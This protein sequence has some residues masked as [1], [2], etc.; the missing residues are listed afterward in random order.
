MI[1]A[2]AY[3]LGAAF[4]VAFAGIWLGM[5]MAPYLGAMAEVRA[6]RWHQAGAV[7]KL[8]GPGL[9][10]G[11]W[12]TLPLEQWLV[13]ALAC[14]VGVWDDRRRMSAGHKALAL[15]LP[16]LAGYYVTQ[17]IW[18]APAIWIAA[19]AWNL[20]DHADGVAAGAALGVLL[21]AGGVPHSI[22]A[23]A[24]FAFL[25]LNFPPARCFL[26]DG[27]SLMLGTAMV[28]LAV[29]QGAAAALLWCA[30]PLADSAL[31]V[32]SRLLRGAAP[33][34]GGMDHSAHRL[35]RL[36]LRPWLLPLLY[37]GAAALTV[38]AGQRL[39]GLLGSA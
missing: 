18:V 21:L 19:N 26:G 14:L 37:A 2:F 30:V 24:L 20:L 8:A 28:L 31:V 34:I 12:F 35:L 6:D 25:L 32:C 36:G 10:A 38:L 3:Q 16:A 7:P 39:L 15:L 5:R 33:W 13:A 22:A 4:V 27:G 11:F 17:Q 1:S 29:P 9:L 23:A